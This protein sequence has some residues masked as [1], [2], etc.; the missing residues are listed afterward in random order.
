MVDDDFHAGVEK[1]LEHDGPFSC[2]ASSIGLDPAFDF[3]N[4]NLR[5]VDF[6]Y[7]DLRGYNFYGSDLSDAL[8]IDVVVDDTTN[9]EE[10]TLTGSIFEK[11]VNVEELF[12][13]K[14]KVNRVYEILKAGDPY[15]ISNWIADRDKGLAK[16]LTKDI[17]DED[18]LLMCQKLLTD[19]IDLTKR[20][21]LFYHLRKTTKD[22]AELRSVVSDFLAF[23]LDNVQVVRSFVKVA[24]DL[25]AGDRFISNAI[26][27]LCQHNDP[28]VRTVAF[29]AISGTETF[30]RHA[31]RISALFLAPKNEVIRKQIL[32]ETATSLS[33]RHVLSINE[34]GDTRDVDLS[35]VLDFPDL[36]KRNSVR[37]VLHGQR[38]RRVGLG[39]REVFQRQ[40]EVLA[41]A[42][43]FSKMIKAQQ[44]KW[45][46]TAIGRVQGTDDSLSQ[47]I[48][49]IVNNAYKGRFR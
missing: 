20:T 25:F 35:S 28:T 19:E 23:H 13:K 10:S 30:I 44:V 16:R 40:Q 48:D 33:F 14:R 43:F 3:Q 47:K 17:S 31:D 38:H 5:G 15:I 1:I 36:L 39:I 49:S 26:L 21:T 46:E 9:F 7:S 45:L 8:G 34:A 24:G 29:I 42:P 4:S 18:A 11:R 32:A 27:S 12:R 2:I 22:S 41:V 37:S 6:S